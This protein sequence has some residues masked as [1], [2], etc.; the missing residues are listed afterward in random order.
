MDREQWVFISMCSKNARKTLV[1]SGYMLL[2]DKAM[3]V[4]M[5]LICEIDSITDCP[6]NTVCKRN[7]NTNCCSTDAIE[8][9][10]VIHT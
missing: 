3:V 5:A 10:A 2:I 7:I 6:M 4:F 9:D 8:A 1:Y